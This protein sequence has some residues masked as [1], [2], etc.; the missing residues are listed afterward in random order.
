[1]VKCRTRTECYSYP[2]KSYH[3]LGGSVN[4]MMPGGNMNP[5]MPGSGSMTSSSSGT[6]RVA[7]GSGMH[8]GLRSVSASVA[9]RF[10]VA[11]SST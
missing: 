8:A 4:P 10:C 1:M 9:F 11:C 6:S 7:S 5:M 3:N 2:N